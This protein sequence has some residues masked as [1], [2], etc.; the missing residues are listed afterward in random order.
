MLLFLAM[1]MQRNHALLA[2]Q[3]RTFLA[4]P[5]TALSF[6]GKKMMIHAIVTYV[7]NWMTG[8]TGCR[9]QMTAGALNK[10]THDVATE[11]QLVKQPTNLHLYTPCCNKCH[12]ETV[13]EERS[14]PLF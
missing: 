11:F 10:S 9:W 14:P 12:V 7:S 4:Q 1:A 2:V 8:W 13:N 5:T 6:T 3:S